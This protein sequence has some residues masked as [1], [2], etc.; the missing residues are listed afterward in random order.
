MEAAASF[1]AVD[2]QAIAFAEIA[3]CLIP[4]VQDNPMFVRPTA[5]FVEDLAASGISAR[6]NQ[7][8]SRHR[9]RVPVLRRR[10]NKPEHHGAQ[11]QRLLVS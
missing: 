9:D 5:F 3:G 4:E 6:E 2:G 11:H 1:A 10:T 8:R 7:L